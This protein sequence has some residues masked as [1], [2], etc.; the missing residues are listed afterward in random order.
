MALTAAEEKELAMLQGMNSSGLTPEE[1]AELAV[2]Q[3]L[4][5][6]E[7][8]E[9]KILQQMPDWLSAQDRLIAKNLA[10][11]PEKQVEFLKQR[12]PGAEVVLHNGEIR[13]KQPSEKDFG[14]LDPN[15]GMFSSDTLYDLG[16]IAYDAGAGF[17]ES[18]ATAAGAAAGFT[19]GGGVGAIPAGMAASSATSASTE[20]FRQKLGQMLG[21]PQEV[22]GTDVAISGG[23]GLIS[24]LLFG[25]GGA[26]KAGV[27]NL[28][29]RGMTQE[30]ATEALDQAGRGMIGRGFS[31]LGRKA[32]GISKEAMDTYSKR[33]AEVDA[34]DEDGLTTTAKNVYDRLNSYVSQNKKQSVNDLH[35]ALQNA[36]GV[37]LVQAKDVFLK[38]INDLESLPYKTNSDLKKLN[39]LKDAYNNY[40]GIANTSDMLPNSVDGSRAFSLQQDLKQMAR[41]DQAMTPENAAAK[42]AAGDSYRAINKS[43]D[44]A[45]GN[46]SGNAKN[47]Y[48]AIREFEDS[49][50]PKFEG[51]TDFDSYQKTLNVLSGVDKDSR[52]IMKE[53]LA[54]MA[55]SGQLDLTPEI[56]LVRAYNELG[57]GSKTISLR[58]IPAGVAGAGIGYLAGAQTGTQG[59]AGVGSL[60]GLGIGGGAASRAMV[61]RY[62]KA[63]RALENA[64][65]QMTPEMLRG[66]PVTAPVANE[67]VPWLMSG[68]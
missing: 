41:F 22:D 35:D 31:A 65:K 58:Q 10:Q 43:L 52:R 51:S 38:Q 30:A 68:E 27:K 16:D 32:T 15:T 12:Y 34:L 18:A 6:V 23:T 5:P 47:R 59:G 28:I 45:T 29:Q 46:L 26:T 42:I 25:T 24:P 62:L 33:A 48:A 21:I 54:K 61:K 55:E 37:D 4:A 14:V 57:K 11:S 60:I 8:N 50:M 1:E 19:A 3:G 49:I 66:L 17:L 40:F 56:D 64:S 13:L 63:N 36:G 53:K 39:A 44:Q 7:Q 2:L 20:A 67:L 9:P